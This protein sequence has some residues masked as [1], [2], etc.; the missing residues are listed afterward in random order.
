MES[1][2]SCEAKLHPE[3]CFENDRHVHFWWLYD[4]VHLC[5]YHASNQHT[6]MYMYNYI[7][8]QGKFVQTLLVILAQLR[9]APRRANKYKQKALEKEVKVG[10]FPK[11]N[12]FPV[13]GLVFLLGVFLIFCF[14]YF[15]SQLRNFCSKSGGVISLYSSFSSSQS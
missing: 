12:R 14:R 2:R 4:N 1:G 5:T 9:P 13:L 11:N 7:F 8:R 10:V 15:L 6:H 3:W